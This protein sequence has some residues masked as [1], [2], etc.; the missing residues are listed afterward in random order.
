MQEQARIPLWKK[1]EIVAS[2]LVDSEDYDALTAHV[3]F[4]SSGGYAV[5]W[6]KVRCAEA[7]SGW[8][9]VVIP[10]HRQILGIIDRPDLW[11]D[12]RHGD[13]LD[14]RKEELRAVTPKQN[15]HNSRAV[16][17]TG[18]KGVH[19]KSNGKFEARINLGQFDT[20]QEAEEKV[21]E[22]TRWLG[23]PEVVR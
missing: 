1:G 7:R 5:R 20:L 15:R 23:R 4:L 18:V 11:G 9:T 14:N 2:S 8:R 10:M 6:E 19:A 12:H 21:E 22:C 16:S 17:S 13:R 3:W